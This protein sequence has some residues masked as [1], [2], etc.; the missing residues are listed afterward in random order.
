MYRLHETCLVTVYVLCQCVALVLGP[1][2]GALSRPWL[3][4]CA[5]KN[6]VFFFFF[7][8][9]SVPIKK[10]KNEFCMPNSR[11]TCMPLKFYCT[12]FVAGSKSYLLVCLLF[13]Y[14][15]R[16]RHKES[17]KSMTLDE[18]Y[19]SLALNGLIDPAMVQYRVRTSNTMSPSRVAHK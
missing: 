11:D 10:L 15:H 1:L 6:D 2:S 19:S 4:Y 8:T 5:F 18:R 9:A 17:M 13:S 7:L 3:R 14:D 12:Q 16:F